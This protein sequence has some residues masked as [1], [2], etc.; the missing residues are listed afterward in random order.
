MGLK[1]MFKKKDPTESEIRESMQDAG[2]TVK[3]DVGGYNRNKF[4]AYKNYAAQVTQKAPNAP[5]PAKQNPYAVQNKPTAGN[6]YAAASSGASNSPYSAASDPYANGNSGYNGGYNDSNGNPPQPPQ[7][8]ESSKSSSSRFKRFGRS[9]KEEA[10]PP[11]PPP[12]EPKL[13]PRQYAPPAAYDEQPRDDYEPVYD[14]G[15]PEE[16]ELPPPPMPGAVNPYATAN[17][18]YGSRFGNVDREL[19]EDKNELFGPREDLPMDSSY[20]PALQEPKYAESVMSMPRQQLSQKVREKEPAPKPASVAEY[21]ESAVAVDEEE[22]LLLGGGST[23]NLGRVD[24]YSYGNDQEYGKQNYTYNYNQ[25]HEFD[26]V[27]EE[28]EKTEQEQEDEDVEAVKQQIRFTKQQSA[29]STRN[30]LRHAAEAEESGRNTLGMLGSQGERLYNIHGTL[31]LA[32]TQH[33]I[34]EEKA[35]ELKTVTRSMFAPHVSNPFNSKRR[36]QEKEDRIRRERA[37]AQVEREQRRRDAYDS[38]Q[39]VVG[40]LD[41]IGEKSSHRKEMMSKYGSRPGRERYQF[42]ADEEDDI[43][44]DEIDNNLDEL[45]SAAGRLKKLGLAMNEEVEQQNEKLDQIAE[46]TDDLDISVHLNTARLA[47]IH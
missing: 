30:A 44:E 19:E 32:T 46:Q 13:G 8:Q 20:N 21:S 29:A 45:S 15:L 25:G 47:G 11:P 23:L 28:E 4:D 18:G 39:R 40:A 5:S 12:A 35:K 17:Q 31:A 33:K 41:G 10:A 14:V 26:T 27:L 36:A 24:S 38:Q 9:K 34:A 6:P 3:T 16:P 1:K 43:L 37:V 7:P 22:D 2:I 42:E